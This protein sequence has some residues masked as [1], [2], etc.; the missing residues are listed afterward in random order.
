MEIKKEKK[1]KG[2]RRSKDPLRSPS[3]IYSKL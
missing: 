2:K 3:L 1:E